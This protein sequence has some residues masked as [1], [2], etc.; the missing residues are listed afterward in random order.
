MATPKIWRRLTG[1][2][3]ATCAA[4][5]LAQGTSLQIS[6]V[7]IHLSL[8]QQA[9]TLTLRNASSEPMYGQVRVF[10]W[11]Q[12]DGEDVLDPTQEIVVTPPLI[13]VAPG[14]TQVIRLLRMGSAD[15]GERAYRL[16]ID[17]IAKP[18]PDPVSGVQV[19]LRYSVP[20]FIG[21]GAGK[22]QEELRWMVSRRGQ[23]W[24]LRVANAGP[25]RAQ[26]SAVTLTAGGRTQSLGEGLLGYALSSSEREWVLPFS[27]P[28]QGPVTVRATVNT[29]ALEATAAR[30]AP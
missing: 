27:L 7:Q 1:F 18:M 28:E 4:G 26:I 10:A 25:Y 20:V 14:T 5:V 8:A 22:P 16:I 24:V 17:E 29:Q 3:L 2:C 30:P 9:T 21:G 11:R 13:Q 12:R 6:P 19:R 23:D 15:K